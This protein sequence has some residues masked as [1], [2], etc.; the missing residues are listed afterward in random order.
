MT[1]R[2]CAKGVRW[3]ATDG[4][5]GEIYL[6][7]AEVRKAIH[8]APQAN[9]WA[10]CSDVLRYNRTVETTLEY[11]TDLLNN[12]I[13][14]W[15]YN[16]DTDLACNFLGDQQYVDQ[17]NL[18]VRQERRIWKVN[19]QI[20]GYVKDFLGMSFMT[21]RGAGHMVPQD[22]PEEALV[23]FKAFLLNDML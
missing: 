23:L 11:V 8:I 4:G 13:R 17:F 5:Q 6:N 9:N 7:S 14:V 15:Y 22:K 19:G 10:I 16:G 18:P 2:E 21:V 1:T 3:T 20:A 12:G